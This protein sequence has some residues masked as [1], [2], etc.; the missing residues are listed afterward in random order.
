MKKHSLL[1]ILSIVIA[2]LLILSWIIPVSQFSGTEMAK[3]DITRI[4]IFD[5]INYPL[6]SFQFF[7][8]MILFILV[9]GG[10]YGILNKTGKYNGLVEKISK[11][12]KGKE[13]PFIVIVAFVFA[14]FSSVFGFSLILFVFIPFIVSIILLL[15]YDKIVAFLVTIASVFVGMIGS[16]YN[17]YINGYINQILTTNYTD[18]IIAK[19]ALFVLTFA[20]FIMFTVKY[21]NKVKKSSKNS[22]LPEK[23]PDVFLGEKAKGK[24]KKKSWPIVVVLSLLFVVFFMGSVPWSDAFGISV[25]TTFNKWLLALDIADHTV[26]AYILGEIG[27]FGTWYF[28][29]LTLMLIIA[30]IILSIVY[31]IKVDD[32]IEAFGEGVK[33]LLKT[34]VVMTL[35]MVVVIIIT[36]H[37]FL[38]TIVD[39]LI[40]WMDKFNIISVFILSVIAAIGSALNIEMV[41][42]SQSILPFLGVLFADAKPIIAVL[43]QAMYGLTM[44]VAPTSLMLILGLEYLEIPYKTWLKFSW[45]LVLEILVIILAIVV[46]ITLA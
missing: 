4:G 39:A 1:K 44:F 24:T 43:F 25:F 16:T 26:I 3:A 28:S 46:I 41:Y 38:P 42:L 45:K 36:Y 21:A 8:Q 2:V 14:A 5:L 29:E 35:A 20:L 31:R 10:F 33:K 37:P 30:S 17:L 27:E 6:L 22:I 15:G 13:L 32:V 19:I 40:G 18:Q 12:L 9:I 7:I 34:I 23:T 11:L